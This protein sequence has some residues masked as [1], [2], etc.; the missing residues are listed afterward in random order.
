[1]KRTLF[2]I[3]LTASLAL[4]ACGQS[5]FSSELEKEAAFE[6]YTCEQAKDSEVNIGKETAIDVLANR[7]EYS[8]EDAKNAMEISMLSNEVMDSLQIRDKDE[9]DLDSRP[10]YAVNPDGGDECFGWTWETYL[11]L[12]KDS[13][14]YAD[15]TYQDAE[16]AGLL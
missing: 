1:M 13:D 7:S 3:A 5:D 6:K 15:F 8:N 16:A 2:P 4:T 14:S 9:P 11:E 10:H 12:Q